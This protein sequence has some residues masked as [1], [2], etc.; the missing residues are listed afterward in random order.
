MAIDTFQ[1]NTRSNR[2]GGQLDELDG[3]HLMQQQ[4][5]ACPTSSGSGGAP[6]SPNTLVESDV[7]PYSDEAVPIGLLTN[8]A[9]S[10]Y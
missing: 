5:Q 8:L 3:E 7:D 6:L 10:L 4:V 1:L 9:I 2:G